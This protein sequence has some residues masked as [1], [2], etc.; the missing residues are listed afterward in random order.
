MS[1]AIV[2]PRPTSDEDLLRRVRRGDAGAFGLLYAHHVAGARCLARSI[3]HGS[4]DAE[5]VVAEAF[6]ASFAAI[7]RGKGPIDG[8]GTYILSCVRH[9]CYRS[10][11]KNGRKQTAVQPAAF[12]QRPEAVGDLDDYARLDEND[13]L[14]G[15][16]DTL[17]MPMRVVLWQTEVEGASHADVA[18]MTG[19]TVQAV[20]TMAMRARRALS[21]NY[22][23]AHLVS[24]APD[25]D[26][27]QC[28][29][30]RNDLAA[31]VRGTASE[32]R[33]RDAMAHLADC[34]SCTEAHGALEAVNQRLRSASL[35][36]LLAGVTL[37]RIVHVGI[38][39]RAVAWI[40]GSV[41]PILA[42]TGMALVG[43]VTPTSSSQPASPPLIVAVAPAGNPT[44]TD[45][46]APVDTAPSVIV[47]PASGERVPM[48]TPAPEPAAPGDQNVPR[49]DAPNDPVVVPTIT[50]LLTGATAPLSAPATSPID[51]VVAGLPP[52]TIPL[53]DDLRAATVPLITIPLSIPGVQPL[54]PAVDTPGLDDLGAVLGPVGDGLGSVGVPGVVALTDVVP[55]GADVAPAADLPT[56]P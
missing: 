21:S 7:T 26:T 56:G 33:R 38:K 47:G 32:R 2:E 31:M 15:A 23:Q 17:P 4:G 54:L 3:L 48:R 50:E 5:D 40:G 53:V 46:E 28:Q 22:L 34:A 12:D 41:T 24:T 52:I 30:V 39:A 16:F 43:V 55:L 14:Q 10:W 35:G 45:L 20:A 25:H 37:R 18:R 36:L 6:A 8:F 27:P 9:E 51:A 1:L 11:R 42:V 49:R 13:V 29:Q 19:S 44:P